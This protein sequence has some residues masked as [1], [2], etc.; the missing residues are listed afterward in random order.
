MMCECSDAAISNPCTPR[1]RPGDVKHS[2]ADMTKAH[3]MLGYEPIVD[4][5]TGL[6][7]TVEW[8]KQSLR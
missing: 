6:K 3:R 4:F 8:Y 7:S 1:A 2:Q 5:K